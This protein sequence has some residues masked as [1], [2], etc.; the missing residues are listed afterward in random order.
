MTHTILSIFLKELKVKHTCYFADSHYLQSPYRDTLYGLSRMLFE[1]HIPNAGIKIDSKELKNIDTPCIAHVKDNFCVITQ[2]NNQVNY[3]LDGKKIKCTIEDFNS[4]WDG[5]ILLAEPDEHS[6]EPDYKRHQLHAF[7]ARY[8]KAGILSLIILGVI[9]YLQTM[10]IFKEVFYVNLVPN[11]VGI[12]LSYWLV[13]KQMKGNSQ[14]GDKLCSLTKQGDCNNILESKAAKLMGLFSWSEIGL[15]FFLSNTILTI[16]FPELIYYYIFINLCT[17]PYSCWSIWYQYKIAR[18]WCILCVA[19]Q[20]V[21]VT[22]SILN[23]IVFQLR[24]PSLAFHELLVVF[25]IYTLPF[26]SINY[27]FR[28]FANKEELNNAIYKLN[29]F[30]ATDEVFIPILKS[31]PF[32]TVDNISEVIFGNPDAN[33]K[34][35]VLTNPHC[36]PCAIAHKRIDKLLSEYEDKFCVQYIFAA[37]NE[38][39]LQSNRFLIAVAL[40]EDQHTQKKIF[41]QWF[42]KEKYFAKEYIKKF[43]YDLSSEVVESELRKHQA[44]REENKINGTPTI[45]INGYKLPENYILEDLIYLT[46]INV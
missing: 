41:T 10:V 18:S 23:I 9:L 31:Q 24:V 43:E 37:F 28:F 36:E 46:D 6:I 39:L 25:I 14:Y 33:L 20:I 19:V 7:V 8:Q 45:L 38:S 15:G 17:L 32:Y 16:F 42:E 1:Y 5:V 27:I 4:I 29:H 26:L 21:L 35:T 12:L 3:I 13:I 11:I 40:H 34:I 2:I 22:I 44:W 30:K